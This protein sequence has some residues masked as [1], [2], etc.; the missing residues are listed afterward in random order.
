MAG[1]EKELVRYRTAAV[2]TAV[3]VGGIFVLPNIVLAVF[4][5][6]LKQGLPGP[7]PGYEKLL[8]EFT[9]FCFTWRLPFALPILAAPFSIAALTS[10]PRSL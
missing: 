9:A 8:L 2:L 5:P 1:S 7:V 4:L 10:K 6:S 3:L